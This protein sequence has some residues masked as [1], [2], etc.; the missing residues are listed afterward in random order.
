M[1][2]HAAHMGVVEIEHVAH[3]AI[4]KRRI[5]PPEF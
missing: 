3:L 4:G 2:H 5:E 1:Q